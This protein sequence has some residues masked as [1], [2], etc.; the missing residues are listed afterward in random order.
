M[1]R[2]RAGRAAFGQDW[3]VISGGSAEAAAIGTAVRPRVQLHEL[4]PAIERLWEAG[5]R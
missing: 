1:T 5:G 2:L 3:A 4:N